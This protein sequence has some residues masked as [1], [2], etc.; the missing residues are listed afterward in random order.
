M[1]LFRLL[2]ENYIK[3]VCVCV[4]VCKKEREEVSVMWYTSSSV[5]NQ[6]MDA[7]APRVSYN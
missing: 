5:R 4:C 7:L 1:C 2:Y 6:V 3:V